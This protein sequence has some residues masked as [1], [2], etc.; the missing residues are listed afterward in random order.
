VGALAC[1]LVALLL[2]GHGGKAMETTLQDDAVFLHRAPVQV[3]AAARQLAALGADRLRLTAGWGVIAPRPKSRQMPGGRF[4]ASDPATYPKGAWTALD[5][6]VDAARA[7]NLKVELDVG[8]WAPRWA[9]RRPSPAGRHRWWP[10]PVLFGQFAHAV[11]QR[12]RGRVDMYVPWNEPNHIAFLAPQWTS[13]GHGGYRPES[14]HVYRA[15]YEAAYRQIKSVSRSNLVL[16]GNT[17]SEGSSVPGRGGVPPL[18]FLRALACVDDKLRPLRVPECRHFRPLKADG[19]AHHPYSRDTTPATPSTAPDDA[20][21]ADSDRL[22]SLLQALALRGR[23]STDLA[24]Y[25]TEFGYESRQDDPFNAPFDRAQQATYLSWASYIA[26]KDP[27]TRMFAQF[28]LD[29]IDPAQSGRTPGTPSF[30]RD[31]QSGLYDDAG[32]PKTAATAFKLPFW[33]ELHGTAGGERAVLLWGQVR[34]GSGVQTVRVEQKTGPTWAPVQTWGPRCDSSD[35]AFYT[36]TTGTFERVVPAGTQPADYRFAW[37]HSS[38][39][40]EHSEPIHVDPSLPDAPEPT[41]A[42]T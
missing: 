38:G 33:A 6:A 28:L 15:M 23:I 12:Y 13:D 21:L 32:N 42:P 2:A 17:S 37:R 36:D 9:V 40:W 26:W 29:D 25:D 39:A 3:R 27:H 16:L 30:Y 10:D 11:A 18:Q 31:W 22:E 7:A 24:V 41:E 35:G 20:P 4:V 14:P 1:G 19:Y 8:F 5:T 34:P